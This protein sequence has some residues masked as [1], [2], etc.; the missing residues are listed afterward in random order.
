MPTARPPALVG[1]AFRTAAW[2]LAYTATAFVGR[3]TIPEGTSFGLIWPAGGV[4]A[5]W[6]LLTSPRLLPVNATLLGAT[7]FTVNYVTGAPAQLAAVLIVTNVLQAVV[8]TYGLRRL[9][10]TLWGCGG[11]EALGAPGQLGRVLAAVVGAVVLATG[12]GAVLFALLVGPQS[13]VEVILWLGRNLCGL[14]L[15]AVP[16][17]LLGRWLTHRNDDAVTRELVPPAGGRIEFLAAALATVGMYFLAFG[18]DDLPLAFPLLVTSVWVGARFSTLVSAL[19]SAVAGSAAVGLTLANTGPFADVTS[20]ILGSLLVQYFVVVV[21][22]L[23]LALATGRDERLALSL[24]LARAEHEASE[25]AALY[26]TVFSS[27]T[28]GV[29]VLD[30][31]GKFLITN[32]AATELMGFG[33]STLPGNTAAITA[34]YAGPGGGEIPPEGKPSYRALHGETVRQMDV[35]YRSPSGEQKT[36]SVS[37]APLP[38]GPDGK[39]RAVL[40]FDD[41]SAERLAKAELAAFARIVAHDLKS[42]LTSIEG[43]VELATDELRASGALGREFA[44]EFTGR[45]ARASARMRQLINDLIQHALTESIDLVRAEIDLG[46]LVRHAVRSR[47]SE[48]S[49]TVADLPTVHGDEVLLRLAVDNVLGNALKYVAPGTRPDVRVSGVAAGD[50]V[51]VR[52]ADNGIGMPPG[53]H[54]QMFAEF[55][56]GAAPGYEGTGLGLAIVRRVITRHGGAVTAY[57]NPAGQGTVVELRLPREH[58]LR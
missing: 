22:I 52:V 23:G 24:R 15:V 56:R 13:P 31:D 57:D 33:K 41:V 29:N 8:A 16:G 35:V 1:Q 19:H 5:L 34:Y 28:E 37:G 18:L 25:R 55:Q 50:E 48:E 47:G 38:P 3:A 49:V 39:R 42:P 45:V 17:L 53:A 21:M 58:T 40:V 54:D 7:A 26:D 44:H 30:E 14:L 11:D 32:D 6:L 2:A 4:A 43:W 12:V 9:C 20:I 27:M 46:S 51:V 10:P 36:F